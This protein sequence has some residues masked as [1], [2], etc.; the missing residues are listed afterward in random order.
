M[1][2]PFL[3]LCIGLM[4]SLSPF[5]TR[6]QS[7]SGGFNYNF[8][9][10][11]TTAQF[12]LPH[13]PK[14]AIS[15]GW[16]SANNAG[17]FLR[18]GQPMRFMGVNITS[19]DAF[20]AQAN[21]WYVAGRLRKMGINLVR[22]HHIDNTW[23]GASLFDYNADTR[24]FNAGYRDKL[25]KLIAELKANGVMVNMNLLVSRRFKASDGVAD[26]DSIADFS[27]WKPAALFDAQLISLQKEYAQAL[28]THVS[29]YTG[30]SLAQ[31]PVLAMMEITNENSIYQ[32]W[33]MNQLKPLARGGVLLHRHHVALNNLWHQYL[34]ARYGTQSVLEA[35]WSGGLPERQN[36]VVNSGFES[37]LTPWN[38]EQHNGA[39]VSA[40]QETASPYNGS[41]SAK[42]IVSNATGTNWH[43]QFKQLNL[44]IKQDSTYTVRFWAKSDASRS[45]SVSIQQSVSPYTYYNGQT[46]TV[47][48]T[49]QAFSYSFT[50]SA[51][52]LGQV[53]LSFSLGATN[54]TYWF[55]D[56][57]L[58]RTGTKGLDA[59]E[60]LSGGTIRRIDWSES[61][62]YDPQ[63]SKDLT[64][65]YIQLQQDYC[66]N[67]TDYLRN[68]LGVQVPVTCTNWGFGLPDVEIQ[69]TS[70]YADSHAYWDHPQFPGVAWDSS[71]WLI[72]NNSMTN[73]TW[74]GTIAGFSGFALAQKPATMSEYMHAF[75]NRYQSEGMLFGTAYAAFHGIDGLMWFDY[76]GDNTTDY[77]PS[78]FAIAR[79]PAMMAHMPNLALAYRKGWIAP[80]SA[81]IQVSF[82]SDDVRAESS[83][84]D[85][86][87]PWNNSFPFNRK[88]GLLH[89]IQIQ[90][91]TAASNFSASGLP[92]VSAS[93][94]VSDT[95]E[96]TW[97]ESGLLKVE[98]PRFVGLTGFLQNFGAMQAGA[99]KLI[100]GSDF[101]TLTWASLT[102][103]PLTT[104]SRS[105]LALSSTMQ[106]TGMVWS[107]T[108]SINNH[109]G[110]APTQMKPL[111]VTLQLQQQA[112]Q[113]RVYPLSNTGVA[114]AYTAYSP[115]SEGIFQITLNQQTDQ[116]LWYGIEAIGTPLAVEE[117]L[118]TVKTEDRDV[119][120]A[121]NNSALDVA[122]WQLQQQDNDEW[123]MIRE[124][125]A[126]SGT[127]MAYRFT[128]SLGG[129]Q[130]YRLDRVR[131]DGSRVIGQPF[132]VYIPLPQGYEV[133]PA[134]PNPFNPQTRFQV[135]VSAPQ[136]V[137]I[138][139]FDGLGRK[140]TELFRGYL[141]ADVPHV[142]YI[143]P[144]DWPSGMYWITTQGAHFRHSQ[145]VI[146][147]K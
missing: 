16:V 137:Q 114:T 139:V 8:P 6:A 115:V 35:A 61:V 27:Y 128:A 59:G 79:N 76:G 119:V 64:A 129:W 75:P 81:P 11:D 72:N 109:W 55:D 127:T 58:M 15:G 132:R 19:A 70:D 38:T 31:D 131:Q 122:F 143:Q 26:A 25:E 130:A 22:F 5:G 144:Q 37:G 3:R 62:Q 107:G 71:N 134:Y 108:T 36:Q 87:N 85:V 21:A 48:T 65:F 56:V 10:T 117:M 140:I 51:T 42:V 83:K 125:P 47:T 116:T 86:G 18:N 44:S 99:L 138:A 69:H 126:A 141:T 12:F 104:A 73:N 106:N 54:G 9:A 82:S 88:R 68:T 23:G 78:Y 4:L 41:H 63:R 20:P 17:E 98:T 95:G 43:A 24:H 39:S 136:Q 45:L 33:R 84:A 105:S 97:D 29:P 77:V 67:M 74:G 80:S 120:L 91:L 92:A 66:Q 46:F 89:G 90:S 135:S 146:F 142:F 101:G 53:W 52:N 123:R 13:F 28:M 94:S 96:I 100:S 121:W 145:R 112:Q 93:P 118:V 14:Q 103:D 32:A 50:A 40:G 60:N 133:S 102:G 124:I 30:L 110:S 2:I 57:K 111:Q 147:L 113:L 49:W 7:F 1:R 34:T